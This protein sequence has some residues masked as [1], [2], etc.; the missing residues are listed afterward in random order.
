MTAQ[1]SVTDRPAG[2]TN[3]TTGSL[4]SRDGTTIGY[5][6]LGHGP[7]LL[8]VQGAMG[9]AHNFMELATGLAESFTVYLP[10]R[11]GRGLSGPA[12]V[13]YS[14]AKEV[15]DLDALMVETG[16]RQVFGLSSG[17]VIA[18]HAAQT[19]GS[20]QRLAIFEPAL[21]VE[22]AMPTA[23]LTRFARELAED[24]IPAAL[25]TSMQATRMGP[26]I[27]NL[28]PRP[29]LEMLTGMMLGKEDRAGSGEYLPMRTLAPT[30]EQDMKIVVE[31]S[32]ELQN[33]A[34]VRID[35]LLLGGSKSPAYLRAALDVLVKLL[36]HATRTEF[37]GLG[38][39]APWNA[40]RGG[41]PEPVAD[42]LRRFF[43]RA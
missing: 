28:I 12:G 30:L 1:S 39:G 20:I 35:V 9:S 16:A 23:L 37:A 22:G 42:A 10:D 26:P 7:G 18:L 11:R 21:F 29:I 33:Y 14:L 40:D 38:H 19:L 32:G 4:V 43:R 27:F 3:H 31:G 15:E 36:P 5:R 25:V 13:D 34:A 2:S 6:Q 8:M 17:A 41:R 24:R